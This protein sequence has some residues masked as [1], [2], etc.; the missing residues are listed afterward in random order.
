MY[1]SDKHELIFPHRPEA[2]FK[3]LL[4]SRGAGGKTMFCGLDH[5]G[6]QPFNYS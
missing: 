2:H 4:S 3:P 6:S 5:S 1:P